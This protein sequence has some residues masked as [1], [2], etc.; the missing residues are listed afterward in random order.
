MTK[1]LTDDI[2]PSL[3]EE[4]ETLAVDLAALGGAQIL[5]ALGGLLTVHYKG[6]NVDTERLKDPVSNIDRVVEEMIRL[7]LAERYPDHAI[8][9]EEMAVS[10]GRDPDFVWA[11]D[12]VDGTSNFVNGF[13]LFASSV[14]LLYQGRPIIGALWCSASHRLTSGIYH[15]RPGSGLQ[16]D[17]VPFVRWSNPMVRRG[18]SGEP[19]PRAGPAPWDSRKTGSAAI[20]CA[21]GAA[22]LLRV[23]YFESPNLWDVAGGLALAT[24]AGLKILEHD[25]SHWQAFDGFGAR[26]DNLAS[27]TRPLILG[28]PSEA[29]A[30]VDLLV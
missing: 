14:G 30:M 20:E 11:I 28:E 9:G 26:G 5:A 23:A 18:L 22:G 29:T 12:P 17:G 6:D 4:L 15:C 10:P 3:L 2:A 1:E 8:V 13:P 21:F 7:R 19:T 16:F 27:W 25:G 24:A